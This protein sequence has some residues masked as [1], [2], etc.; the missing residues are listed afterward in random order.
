ME[1]GDI[2]TRF[3]QDVKHFRFDQG[4]RFLDFLF[5]HAEV[6]KGDTVE[7]F[8]QGEHGRIAVFTHV[9]Q[10]GGNRCFHLS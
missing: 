8:C 6:R 1:S 9:L 3:L 2:V 10:N 4:Q 5:R 7:F